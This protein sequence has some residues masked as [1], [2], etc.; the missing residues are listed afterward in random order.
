MADDEMTTTWWSYCDH[1]V[2]WFGVYQ[3][4][5][6]YLYNDQMTKTWRNQSGG[7]GLAEPLHILS[8]AKVPQQW[9]ESGFCPGNGHHIGLISLSYLCHIIVTS[10]SFHCHNVSVII[11]VFNVHFQEGEKRQQACNDIAQSRSPLSSLSGTSTSSTNSSTTLSSSS[12]LSGNPEQVII[13]AIVIMIKSWSCTI[14]FGHGC[15]R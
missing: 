8:V 11:F 10:L 15:G 14:V 3:V 12:N 7:Q 5:E 6:V 13:L 2:K 4:D 9:D 1:L